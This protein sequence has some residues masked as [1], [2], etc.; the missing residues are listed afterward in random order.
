VGSQSC[1][2]AY[3]KGVGEFLIPEGGEENPA[4][5]R[6]RHGTL[7]CGSCWCP[8]PLPPPVSPTA[9]SCSQCPLPT[10]SQCN[11]THKLASC[12]RDGADPALLAAPF[13]YPVSG[14]S[15]CLAVLPPAWLLAWL[16]LST[17]VTHSVLM[18]LAFTHDMVKPHRS[19]SNQNQANKGREGTLQK[20]KHLYF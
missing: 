10:S 13:P 17:G 14:L 2:V 5:R 11:K 7:L 1:G 12:Q 15:C 20:E 19:G 18:C 6:A 4:R 9:P 16:L 8:A 3:V